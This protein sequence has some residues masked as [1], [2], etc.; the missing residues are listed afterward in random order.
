MKNYNEQNI[1]NRKTT[2]TTIIKNKMITTE[3]M[4]FIEEMYQNHNLCEYYY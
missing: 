3:N 1:I 4:F 2:V